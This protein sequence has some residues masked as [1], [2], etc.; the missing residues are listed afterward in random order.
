MML[1]QNIKRMRQTNS[2]DE[3]L[4]SIDLVKKTWKTSFRKLWLYDSVSTKIAN[5]M[6]GEV[7]L[8][9]AVKKKRKN[10]KQKSNK[11]AEGRRL[12]NQKRQTE[13]FFFLNS[14]TEPDP[15]RNRNSHQS[16]TA[17]QLWYT[18]A[19]TK[20]KDFGLFSFVSGNQHC[21]AY[22]GRNMKC[23][24]NSCAYA[25][26]LLF[27]LLTPGLNSTKLYLGNHFLL[28]LTLTWYRIDYIE[29]V[30]INWQWH[31]ISDR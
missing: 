14:P 18:P 19:H 25:L 21:Y 10:T 12:K 11:Q 20:K 17:V 23:G 16:E 4:T 13:I 5:E 28:A 29:Y 26:F 24:I 2:H 7:I 15:S 31:L 6:V 30:Y 27:A 3:A 22:C 9:G 8:K 1:F